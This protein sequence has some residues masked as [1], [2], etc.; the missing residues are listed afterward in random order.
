M[1]ECR[2][3]PVSVATA[4]NS[5]V[6]AFCGNS[7]PKASAIC[8]TSTAAASAVVSRRTSASSASLLSWWS[9]TALAAGGAAEDRPHVAQLREAAGVHD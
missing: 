1:F 9:I 5:G 3:H 6:T 2:N 7:H 4:A 8:T